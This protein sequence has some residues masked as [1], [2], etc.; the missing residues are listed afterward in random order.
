MYVVCL[1]R[2]N[3]VIRLSSQARL[4]M[5]RADASLCRNLI[6]HMPVGD[7]GSIKI[8]MEDEING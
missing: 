6:S 3:D 2:G 8:V 7:V 5:A 1:F 4:T